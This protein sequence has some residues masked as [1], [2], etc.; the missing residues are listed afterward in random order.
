MPDEHFLDAFSA[1]SLPIFLTPASPTKTDISTTSEPT[2]PIDPTK[3]IVPGEVTAEDLRYIKALRAEAISPVKRLIQRMASEESL[4]APPASGPLPLSCCPLE[5]SPL[6]GILNNFDLLFDLTIE[7]RQNILNEI[8]LSTPSHGIRITQQAPEH[9]K[10][11][12]WKELIYRYECCLMDSSITVELHMQIAEMMGN[13]NTIIPFPKT[14]AGAKT[15]LETFSE[16]V[17]AQLGTLR[18]GFKIKCPKCGKKKQPLWDPNIFKG[19]ELVDEDGTVIGDI[20]E[21]G[22]LGLFVSDDM[23]EFMIIEL[24]KMIAAKANEKIEKNAIA[25]GCKPLSVPKPKTAADVL[26]KIWKAT[27]DK[28]FKN[29]DAMQDQLEAYGKQKK[30]EQVRILTDI[31]KP[32]TYGYNTETSLDQI[33]AN[34][35]AAISAA[36]DILVRE[37]AGAI[38]LDMPAEMKEGARKYL[39]RPEREMVKKA[40]DNFSGDVKGM[41]DDLKEMGITKD[42][43]LGEITKQLHDKHI[44]CLKPDALKPNIPKPNVPKPSAPKPK[45][46]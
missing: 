3:L 27:A 8:L 30:K 18:G 12:D 31:L 29:A 19:M 39:N 23:D 42:L 26:T 45:K 44:K 11:A 43:T 9:I 1:P 36:N 4:Q 10:P 40:M 17:R 24:K 6:L 41:I 35:D 34:M 38:I 7:A 15:P 37:D 14:P 13:N 46:K 28:T 22:E 32:N 5:I 2:D 16:K 33:N 21:N 20:D 25:A